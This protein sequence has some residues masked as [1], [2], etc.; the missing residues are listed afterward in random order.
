MVFAKSVQIL[1]CSKNLNL[2]VS[3]IF[4]NLVSIEKRKEN[5]NSTSKY[6]NRSSSAI[7]LIFHFNPLHDAYSLHFGLCRQRGE[8]VVCNEPN[9]AV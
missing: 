4:Y 3:D 9:A 7:Q 8:F 6:F 5:M 1:C 2:I